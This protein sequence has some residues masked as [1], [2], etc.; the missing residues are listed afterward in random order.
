[1]H[2]LHHR[3]GKKEK[4]STKAAVIKKARALAV[5]K[6]PAKKKARR[7]VRPRTSTDLSVREDA[8]DARLIREAREADKGKARYRVNELRERRGLATI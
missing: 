3:A 2:T 5:Q 6:S 1:M 7:Y 8:L 4:A